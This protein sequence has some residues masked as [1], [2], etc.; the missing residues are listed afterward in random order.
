MLEDHTHV[1]SR[2]NILW[3]DVAVRIVEYGLCDSDEKNVCV[4]N[5]G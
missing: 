1:T 2:E 5:I 4:G 3:S